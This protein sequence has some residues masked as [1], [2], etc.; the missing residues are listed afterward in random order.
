MRARILLAALVALA[1]GHGPRVAH[2]YGDLTA[3]ANA[4]S[5]TE[6]EI[7]WQWYEYG[8]GDPAGYPEWVGYDLHR[9]N[10]AECSPWVR[11]NAEIIPRVPGATHGGTIVDVPPAPLITWEYQLRPVDAAHNPVYLIGGYC[12]PPCPAHMWE[13]IPKLAGPVTVGT[14]EMDLGW[15]VVIFGCRDGCW[16]SFNVTE[17]EA[18]LLRPYLGTGEAFRFY[19]DEFYGTFEGS[20][21]YLDRFEPAGC[22]PTPAVRPTW[23]SVKTRYR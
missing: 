10:P 15:T 13:S 11:L 9:R 6:I 17:P 18:S 7:Q 1:L 20:Y 16:Y 19:G 12:E 3:T 14:V 2:A 22:G 21:L 5:A 23:G 8:P 4:T